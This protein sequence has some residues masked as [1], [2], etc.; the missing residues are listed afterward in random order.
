MAEISTTLKFITK[1]N[2]IHGDRY[3][4]SL[5][6]YI[7]NHT[8]VK[9]ICREHGVFEQYPWNHIKG[10][11]CLKCSVISS[12]LKKLKKHTDKF[13]FKSQSIHGNKYDYSKVNYTRIK[14]KVEI[15]CPRHGSFSQS[16]DSHMRGSICPRCN[17]DVFANLYK[18]SKET[19]IKKADLIHNNKYDYSQITYINNNTKIKV[20]CPKHGEFHQTPASHLMRCGCPQCQESHGEK[21]IAIILK[22]NDIEFIKEKTFPTC[23]IE[24]LLR[25]DFYI[26]KLNLLIEY[27]GKQHFKEY[28][29]FGG[30][31][32]FINLVKN[33][34]YKER[35]ATENKIFLQIYKY[36]DKW[37][38]I[39]GDILKL[40]KG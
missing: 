28:K 19:F 18:S 25:F 13:L 11:G 36:T 34:K 6:V 5:V 26:S 37:D 31:P 24:R 4:Y 33:D 32:C 2:N 10:H 7:N 8:K 14:N 3:D 39:E 29:W 9:I 12:N 23:K 22:N 27:H 15:I 16:A 35:W 1:S 17:W 40:I 21:R 20:V 30:L 38:Y